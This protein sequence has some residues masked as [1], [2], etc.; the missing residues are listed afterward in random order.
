MSTRVARAALLLSLFAYA[1]VS[2]AQGEPATP[3]QATQQPAS[4][5]NLV[6]ILADVLGYSDIG[7]F[8]GDVRTPN[9]DALAAGGLRFTNF[10]NMARCCPTWAALLTGL[11]PH[12]A[13]VGAMTER[14]RLP[15]YSGHIK[16]T[17]PTIV[18]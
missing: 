5:P 18:L 8:G 2:S 16:P 6:I 17:T 9:L 14:T 10:Y 12:Q 4:R 13:G 15:A 7:C 11:Y 1:L 3:E